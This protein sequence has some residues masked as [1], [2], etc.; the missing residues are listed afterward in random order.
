[1]ARLSTVNVVAGGGDALAPCLCIKGPVSFFLITKTSPSLPS[2]LSLSYELWYPPSV[3][4]HLPAF[5]Y[6]P[7]SVIL[8]F[9][10]VCFF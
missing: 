9:S 1:M 3:F 5:V 10:S 8:V 6:P 7:L 2:Y 4:F